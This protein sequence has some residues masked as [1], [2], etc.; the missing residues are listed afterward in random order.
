MVILAANSAQEKGT[1]T[2]LDRQITFS[3]GIS[4]PNLLMSVDIQTSILEPKR[5]TAPGPRSGG[6]IYFCVD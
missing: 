4:G 6:N 5:V 3:F 1:L 2:V